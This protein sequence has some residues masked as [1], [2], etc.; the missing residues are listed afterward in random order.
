[1][2]S[3]W[4]GGFPTPG[5]SRTWLPLA[6]GSRRWFSQCPAPAELNFRSSWLLSQ[7]W[8]PAAAPGTSSGSFAVLPERHFSDFSSPSPAA[9]GPPACGGVEGAGAGGLPW[10]LRWMP[11]QDHHCHGKTSPKVN[12]RSSFSF[13]H[14]HTCCPGAQTQKQHSLVLPLFT[15]GPQTSNFS[16]L[17]SK[18]G[19]LTAPPS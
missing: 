18:T 17:I 11:C 15:V 10:V 9:S 3:S 13:S 7:R 1:M 16:V 19:T 2:L 4:S 8:Q 5:S 14:W 12:V 6:S